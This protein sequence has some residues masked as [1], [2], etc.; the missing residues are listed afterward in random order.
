MDVLSVLAVFF[1]EFLIGLFGAKWA[2]SFARKMGMSDSDGFSFPLGVVILLAAFFCISLVF[3]NQLASANPF[4][5][6]AVIAMGLVVMVWADMKLSSRSYML[7]MIGICFVSSYFLPTSLSIASGFNGLIT[8]IGLAVV[9]AILVWLFVQMDR[10]PFLSMTLSLVFAVFYF[11]LSNFLHRF[12]PVF[13]YLALTLVVVLLGVNTYLK[14]GHSPVLGKIASTFVG[15]IWGGMAVYVVASG[16]LTAVVILYSYA[17]MEVVLS[18]I[19]SIAIYQRFGPFYPFLI[20]QV[21][22]NK[23]YPEKA[24]KFIMRWELLIVCLAILATLNK[25]FPIESFY[26]VI[27]LLSINIYMRLKAWGEPV[28][29]LRDLFRDTKQSIHQVTEEIKKMVENKKQ[30]DLMK[31]KETISVEESL[32]KEIKHLDVSV[33]EQSHPNQKRAVGKTDVS[34]KKQTVQKSPKNKRGG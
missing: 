22:I 24:L 3:A 2:F 28:V 31:T 7:G 23:Q 25:T 33:P 9:W 15:F 29:R 30:K 14:K 1:A 5:F 32:H 12:D 13:G 6:Y 8:H 34:N 26:V 20:E 18:I 16:H 19:A 17:I 11:L 10:I 4:F 27:V 21:L